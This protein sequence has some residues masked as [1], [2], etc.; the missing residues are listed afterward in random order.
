MAGSFEIKRFNWVRMQTA[1]EQ[2][3]A[4]R[5]KRR[6]MMEEFQGTAAAINDSL[7]SAQTSL[8]DGL[9][10]LAAEAAAVRVQNEIGAEIDTLV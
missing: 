6:A 8:A 5:E 10:Q 3:E 2:S 7:W 1:W 9:A 4:W